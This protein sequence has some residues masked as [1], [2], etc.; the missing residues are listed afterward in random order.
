MST[1]R[2]CQGCGLAEGSPGVTWHNRKNP[3]AIG[4]WDQVKK[5]GARCVLAALDLS[6]LG[7]RLF[8]QTCLALAGFENARL[9]HPLLGKKK[10]DAPQPDPRQIRMF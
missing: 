7:E 5:V 9:Q 10:K 1:E 8:C 4:G 3:N 2:H 6:G